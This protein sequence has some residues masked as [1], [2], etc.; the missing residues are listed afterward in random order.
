MPSTNVENVPR[1]AL[2][3]RSGTRRGNIMQLAKPTIMILLHLSILLMDCVVLR[4]PVFSDT[5]PQSW[6]KNGNI[7][8]PRSVGLFA[9]IFLSPWLILPVFHCMGLASNMLPLPRQPGKIGPDSLS[10]SLR[11]ASLF[12]SHFSL[13]GIPLGPLLGSLL[14][15]VTPISGIAPSLSPLLSTFANRVAS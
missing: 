2:L 6:Q 13:V 11:L 14:L 9:L 8:T 10:T 5:W 15:A 1:S 12:A 7:P 3:V 4:Q